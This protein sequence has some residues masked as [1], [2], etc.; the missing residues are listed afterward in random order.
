MEKE[1]LFEEY[2]EVSRM[3]GL[4]AVPEF[5][6]PRL[7]GMPAG[8]VRGRVESP[9][10]HAD[11]VDRT[12]LSWD[13]ACILVEVEPVTVYDPGPD[14]FTET[15]LDGDFDLLLRGADGKGYEEGDIIQSVA[16]LVPAGSVA[17][18]YTAT[19]TARLG[20][21][22]GQ[23]TVT[24][25]AYGF[26]ASA[27]LLEAGYPGFPEIEPTIELVGDRAVMFVNP[28]SKVSM[29]VLAHEVGHVLAVQ[30][31]PSDPNEGRSEGY[32]FPL[33]GGEEDDSVGSM[34]RLPSETVHRARQSPFVH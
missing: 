19:M 7:N 27:E 3:A 20:A 5:M 29:R 31:D 15:Y 30:G 6:S 32:F 2:W 24:A 23:P 14:F 22:P 21:S 16:A 9:N 11:V 12:R 13:Q 8:Q 4:F 10:Y 34:R 17:V 26:A 33:H 25:S 1:E 18:V 28:I